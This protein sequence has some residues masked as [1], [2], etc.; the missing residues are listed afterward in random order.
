M[1]LD[2]YSFALAFCVAIL[3]GVAKTGMP[4][5][6]IV[7]V[8]LMA[9]AVPAKESVG[10]LVLLMLIGD[11]IAVM[12]YRQ[13]ADLATLKKI[14]PFVAMGILPGALLLS[15]LDNETARPVLGLLVASLVVL[16]VVRRRTSFD[17]FIGNKMLA[18]TIGM[19]AGLATVVGNAA[20]PI[21]AIYF[22][23]L[24]LSKQ[25]FMGTF[26]WFFFI[27]N[28]SKVPIYAYLDVISG[29]TFLL[30]AKLSLGVIIG[31]LLGTR[32]F[33]SL[34]QANFDWAILVLTTIASVSLLFG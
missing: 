14:L 4:A 27:V 6:G 9:M 13:F 28:A 11:T 25:T 17:R 32:L 23:L 16:E 3:V 5:M 12:R 8:P 2:T 18:G 19:L 24:A 34:S 20:G 26:A 29:E 22:L 33:K 30:V 7:L 10:V 15:R 31:A 1:E 21:M